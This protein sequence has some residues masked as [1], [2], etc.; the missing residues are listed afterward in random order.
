M[1]KVVWHDNFDSSVEAAGKPAK[2]K[3]RYSTWQCTIVSN[4]RD[5]P[6]VRQRFKEVIMRV[7]SDKHLREYCKGEVDTILTVDIEGGFE[8][9]PKNNYPH[10]HFQVNTRQ[11]G[12]I[13]LDYGKI[14]DEIDRALGHSP[15]KSIEMHMVLYKGKPMAW[16]DYARKHGGRYD[17]ST[18]VF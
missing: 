1:S 8:V 4:M 17:G 9:G 14:R 3:I 12:K 15:G 5:S 16:V 6:E 13:M 18:V 11:R 2:P 7:F 10:C